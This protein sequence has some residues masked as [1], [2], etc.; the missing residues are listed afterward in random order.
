MYYN[1]CRLPSSV[2][3]LLRQADDFAPAQ[4]HRTA[5]AAIRDEELCRSTGLAA[6]VLCPYLD[7]Q[8]T[9]IM[10]FTHKIQGIWAIVLGTLEVLVSVWGGA[11]RSPT[12][13]T[14]TCGV[15]GLCL[16]S[17]AVRQV[18]GSLAPAAHGIYFG[19]SSQHILPISEIRLRDS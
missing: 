4:Q 12:S 8:S 11:L 15:V 18:H 10:A 3:A 1:E 7:L 16:P 6:F 2:A 5:V 14:T 13:K 9:Q 17:E 19:M